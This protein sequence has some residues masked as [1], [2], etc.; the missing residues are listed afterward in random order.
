[1][2]AW[3]WVGVAGGAKV[4][5]VFERGPCVAILEQEEVTAL[6]SPFFLSALVQ[7]AVLHGLRTASHLHL[8]HVAGSVAWYWC[9]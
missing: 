7:G 2:G 3:W 5:R 9:I 8:H 6:C 1:M 4:L